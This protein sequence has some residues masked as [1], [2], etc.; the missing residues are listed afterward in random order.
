M[1]G[2]GREQWRI[3]GK[4]LLNLLPLMI[5]VVVW[6]LGVGFA[7]VYFESTRERPEYHYSVSMNG[8]G[9]LAESVKTHYPGFFSTGDPEFTIKT[10]AGY[11]LQF[12]NEPLQITKLDG[13][14]PS[15]PEMRPGVPE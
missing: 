10:C 13:P 2:G 5:F 4:A 15:L 14:C 11:E 9:I 1:T 12:F 8:V 3:A 6:S 7:F